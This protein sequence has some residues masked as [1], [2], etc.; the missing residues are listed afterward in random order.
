MKLKYFDLAKNMSKK[1]T[2]PRYKIGGVVV[3]KSKIIS[4]G[5]NRAKTHPQSNHPHKNIHCELDCV[6]GVDPE[7]LRDSTLYLYIPWASPKHLKNTLCRVKMSEQQL[8][9]C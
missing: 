8:D 7:L 9:E 2:H 6:L 1:S 4:L 5:F 3:K